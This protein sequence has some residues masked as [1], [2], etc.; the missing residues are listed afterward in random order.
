[1]PGAYS[2]D[3]R[4][5][6]IAAI[7]CGVPKSEVITMFNISRDSLD[8]WL[9]RRAET[10]SFQAIQGYQQGHSHRIV[11]WRAFRTFV[12]LHGDKTQ[13]ELAELWHEPVSSRTISRA[14]ARIGFARK[15]TRAAKFAGKSE[16]D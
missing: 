5:K 10:G 3:L 15:K 16:R 1:M 12:K 14:F 4:E 7:D 2:Q 13:A 8:R 11:D 6:A 9:K